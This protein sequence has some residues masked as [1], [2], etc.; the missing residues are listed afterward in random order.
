MKGGI[1]MSLDNVIIEPSRLKDIAKKVSVKSLSPKIIKIT[2]TKSAIS[3][4]QE[5]EEA[6]L[7]EKKYIDK[8]INEVEQ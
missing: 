2:M 8:L 4:A 5:Y 7:M 3:L 1:D 6:I